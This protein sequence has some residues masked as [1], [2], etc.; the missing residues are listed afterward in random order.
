MKRMIALCVVGL[1]AG[2]TSALPIPMPDACGTCHPMNYV[3]YECFHTQPPPTADCNYNRKWCIADYMLT[4]ACELESGSVNQCE[5][6]EENPPTWTVYQQPNSLPAGNIF[7]VSPP[8]FSYHVW[9]YV[10]IGC[11]PDCLC[12]P[13]WIACQTNY[14]PDSPIF[15]PHYFGVGE[16]CGCQ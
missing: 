11:H 13:Y 3:V 7:C 16:E 12:T 8:D 6:H 10:C 1:V 2:I 14:C 9:K 4:N 15:A 5:A